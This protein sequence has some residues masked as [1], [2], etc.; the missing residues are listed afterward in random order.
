MEN[1]SHADP[2]FNS[3]LQQLSEIKTTTPVRIWRDLT[4]KLPNAHTYLRQVK[5]KNF[6]DTQDK[7][8]RK[9][10]ICVKGS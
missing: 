5:G 8:H 3:E 9:L 2:D 6:F 1:S 10:H 7:L 4:R